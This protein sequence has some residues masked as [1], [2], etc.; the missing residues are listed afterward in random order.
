MVDEKWLAEEKNQQYD[1]ENW[2]V[3]SGKAWGNEEDPEEIIAKQKK[4]KEQKKS[5]SE[6]KKHKLMEH[7]ER[8]DS[9][10][11]AK[12]K[13]RKKQKGKEN[14]AG[15]TSGTGTLLMVASPADVDD[16]EMLYD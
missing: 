4:V 3:I 10:K 2:I 12:G 7:A 13:S 14:R 6:E 15:R 5:I 1:D 11:K 8:I 9:V 16:N